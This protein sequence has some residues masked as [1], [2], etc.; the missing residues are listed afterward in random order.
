MTKLNLCEEIK[1][2]Q[3]IL[4][5]IPLSV[6]KITYHSLASQLP[7]TF[8][9]PLTKLHGQVISFNCSDQKHALRHATLISSCCFAVK[10]ILQKSRST[11]LKGPEIFIPTVR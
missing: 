9:F 3:I 6:S 1:I 10:G 11:I 2:F 7:L 5:N 4:S 8:R